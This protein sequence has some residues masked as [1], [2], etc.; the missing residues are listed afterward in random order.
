MREGLQPAAKSVRPRCETIPG[1][2]RRE[3][4]ELPM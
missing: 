2:Q 3:H 1:D 4:A